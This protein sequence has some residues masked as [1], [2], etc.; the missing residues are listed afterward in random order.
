MN[1][2]VNHDHAQCTIELGAILCG[3][4][5]V[6][7]DGVHSGMFGSIEDDSV[8][9]L[10][11]DKVVLCMRNVCGTNFN[12]QTGIGM[13]KLLCVSL[14][15]VFMTCSIFLMGCVLKMLRHPT[16]HGHNMVKLQDEITVHIRQFQ[17]DDV[18]YIAMGG[19][20]GS[21]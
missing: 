6:D 15:M 3:S 12:Y 13:L 2:E 1:Q 4:H 17:I 7:P 11:L 19:S 14:I 5:E 8:L 10:L 16:S 21:T 9:L 20:V 18:L